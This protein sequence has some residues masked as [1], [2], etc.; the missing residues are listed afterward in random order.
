MSIK[1][2]RI[3]EC[4]WMAAETL[5][6]AIASHTNITGHECEDE[7]CCDGPRELTDAEMDTFIFADEDGS[8][9]TF[10]E[11]LDRQIAAGVTFPAFFASTEF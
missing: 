11:E 2:F 4:D 6:A 10:R 1:V 7:G 5:E 8:H 9:R 3:N